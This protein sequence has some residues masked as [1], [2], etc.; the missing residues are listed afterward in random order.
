MEA[1]TQPTPS[2]WSLQGSGVGAAA[3]PSEGSSS[4]WSQEAFSFLSSGFSFWRRCTTLGNTRGGGRSHA[5]SWDHPARATRRLRWSLGRNVGTGTRLRAGV[6]RGYR[7]SH[8]ALPPL[9][10]Q[11]PSLAL[12]AAPSLLSGSSDTADV[13]P[14]GEAL[15]SSPG[16]TRKR[17]FL[18]SW[19][20]RAIKPSLSRSAGLPRGLTR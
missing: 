20:L 7:P 9:R 19:E 15:A 14:G 11:A 17:G 16:D 3:V 5:R 8:P 4:P 13:G 1:V 6:G 12:V 2:P 10:L 18:L